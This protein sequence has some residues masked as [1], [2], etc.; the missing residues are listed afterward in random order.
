MTIYVRK[1]FQKND[2]ETYDLL[3]LSCGHYPELLQEIRPP[4]ILHS[5]THTRRWKASHIFQLPVLHKSTGYSSVTLPWQATLSA[6]NYPAENRSASRIA[7]S[8]NWRYKQKRYTADIF[9]RSPESGT[10]RNVPHSNPDSDTLTVIR[11]YFH[12]SCNAHK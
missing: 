10:C 3:I 9:L 11:T 8:P 12:F 2:V 7:L 6:A 5:C 4:S 1:F